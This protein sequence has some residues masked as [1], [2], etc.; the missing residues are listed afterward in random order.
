MHLVSLREQQVTIDDHVFHFA[1]GQ[2]IVTEYSHKYTLENFQKLAGQA[3]FRCVKTWQDEDK[4]FS[5]FY[6]S[7]IDHP[8]ND[9]A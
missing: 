3:G 6:L 8:D 4:L 9:K 2:S 7:V 5:I 1:K